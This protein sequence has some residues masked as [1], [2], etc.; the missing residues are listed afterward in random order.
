MCEYTIFSICFMPAGSSSSSIFGFSSFLSALA[1]L[2]IV[3]TI[4]GERY[5]F[6]IATAPLPLYSMT[7]ILISL[8][9]VGVL[10]SELWVNQ[11]WLTPTFNISQSL[12][13]STFAMVFLIIVAF[14]AYY[15]LM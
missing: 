14:W 9:G 7:F 2:F 3:Y 5:K 8:I 15:G 6:R 11:K 13:Q 10:I 4:A 12:W 1:L